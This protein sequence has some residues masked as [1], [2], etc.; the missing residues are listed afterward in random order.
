MEAVHSSETSAKFYQTT[1]RHIPED[2]TLHSH[3]RENLTCN[4][5][6]CTGVRFL[7][8]DDGKKVVKLI[9]M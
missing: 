3:R 5:E 6:L 1:R 7:T 8:N 2:S 9:E 4:T